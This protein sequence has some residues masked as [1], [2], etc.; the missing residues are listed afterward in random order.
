MAVSA[1]QGHF[2]EVDGTVSIEAE[3]YI[4]KT[5]GGTVAAQSP[6]NGVPDPLSNQ[7]LYIACPD[8]RN[9]GFKWK[10][11]F[12]QT[13]TYQVWILGWGNDNAADNFGV[14]LG[15][16]PGTLRPMNGKQNCSY[17]SNGTCPNYE[18][19]IKK[20]GGSPA[21]SKGDQC[22]SS[23]G[24]NGNVTTWTI[25]TPGTYE[26]GIHNG[27]EPF[28]SHEHG[29]NTSSN[30]E[31]TVKPFIVVDK[32]VITKGSA[33][34]GAGPAATRLGARASFSFSGISAAPATV[35]FDASGSTTTSGTI[36]GYKWD[37]G[38]QTSGTGKV[39]THT[40]TEN[41]SYTVT[42]TVTSSEGSSATTSKPLTIADPSAF[43][44]SINAG[45]TTAMNGFR[46]DRQWDGEYGYEGG[47]SVGPQAGVSVADTEL[48]G[49]FSS[50]RHQNFSYKVAVPA[51]GTYTV[52]LLFAEFW[53]DPGQRVFTAS[54]EGN[55]TG[56]IDIADAVGNGR[57]WSVTR[58]VEVNDGVVD[59]DFN[60]VKDNPM[61]S[62]IIVA[63]GNKTGAG[64][65]AFLPT[66]R[67]APVRAIR[68]KQTIAFQGLCPGD[69]I[70]LSSVQGRV[71]STTTAI[72]TSG[73]IR[74]PA[75]STLFLVSVSRNGTT[76]GRYKLL[77]GFPATIK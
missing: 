29:C 62:G 28:E 7:A 73:S 61:V 34:S 64:S 66:T 44:I 37:F 32:I 71:I 54:V 13:G 15:A 11:T 53:R 20:G 48:D 3:E 43:A 23:R 50:V 38:D 5:G 18:A 8:R 25:N 63:A 56:N 24:C 65:P 46:A 69:L 59:I 26:M 67:Y 57:A 74:I 22:I 33:P 75:A 30:Q 10:V 9:F 4:A 36:T 40:F 2:Q 19:T 51:A 1:E 55:A 17:S 21:W 47:S 70:T 39:V 45:A 52:E 58:V 72:G 76:V 49:V 27:D 68:N 14:F 16:K 42:L 60:A 12:E 6:E 41:K 35:T 77:K 31:P